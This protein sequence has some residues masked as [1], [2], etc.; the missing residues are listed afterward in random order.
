MVVH[1]YGYITEDPGSPKALHEYVM[2]LPRR[3]AE[4]VEQA[5]DQIVTHAGAH[6]PK[7]DV[8]I[9]EYAIASGL[10]KGISGIDAP[11]GYRQSLDGALYLAQVLKQWIVLGIPLAQKHSLI[12]SD[13][14]N[15]PEGYTKV[16]TAE[17]AIIGPHP[18]FIPS[19]SAHVFKMFT[20]MMGE[21][22][23]PSWVTGN[24]SAKTTDG[25][26]LEQLVTVASSD[27]AGNVYLIVVNRD[28]SASATANIDV[29][30][31]RHDGN[32][33]AWSLNGPSY[34][35]YN[36]IER[37]NKVAI[38]TRQFDDLGDRFAFRFPAH[39]VTALKL[40]DASGG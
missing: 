21:T 23:V 19:A 15:P 24:R 37:P 31:F 28:S 17:S 35:A 39:S 29:R 3:Q 4:L 8:V 10:D 30:G 16:Q 38:R 20:S 34:L 11:K 32:L 7:I 25:S 33:T 9:S 40:S 12:D 6:A 1:S 27:D 22:Y 14:E 36:T 18:C 2:R 5:Q 13:P 26:R